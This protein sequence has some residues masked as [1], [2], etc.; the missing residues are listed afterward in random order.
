M[1]SFVC[2]LLFV[3]CILCL[4]VDVVGF[5]VVY[6]LPAGFGILVIVAG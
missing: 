2:F 1:F 4:W 6:L 3:F 5:G